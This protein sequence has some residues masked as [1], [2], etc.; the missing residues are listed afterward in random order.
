MANDISQDIADK[1]TRIA[2]LQRDASQR[3][4]RK[5]MEDIK[6][7]EDL[8][9]NVIKK[10]PGVDFATPFPVMSGILDTLLAKT[11][12]PPAIEYVQQEEADLKAAKKY[13]AAW[14]AESSSPR[15]HARWAQKD[16]F[17]KKLAG[18]SGRG[19]FQF[20]SESDPRYRS[21]LE[22]VDHYD[23][24]VEPGGGSYIQNH[25]YVQKDN[26]FRTKH[27]LKEGAK[28]RF[29]DQAQVMKLFSFNEGQT[30]RDLQNEYDDKLNRLRA[31]GIEA[32]SN[33]FTGEQLY[34]LTEAYTTYEGQRYQL[35]YDRQSGIW[36]RIAKLEEVF[37]HELWPFVSWATHEDPFLFWSKAPADDIRPVADTI[38]VL[39]NQELSNRERRNFNK[40]AFDEEMFEASDLDEWRR[41]KLVPANTSGGLKELSRGV[42][43]FETPEL[44]GTI[45]L[46]SFMDNF[47]GQKTGITPGAQGVSEDDKKVGV[48]FGELQQVSD[49]LGLINKSY[50]MGWE[51]LGYMYKHGLEE[52]LNYEM[53]ITLV[54]IEGVERTR[55]TRKDLRTKSDFDVS[56]VSSQ[57]RAQVQE[58]EQ[59]R[60]ERALDRIVKSGQ[61]VN[62]RWL[63]EEIL[64]AGGYEE[65]QIA[66]ALDLENETSEEL[67]SEAAAAIQDILR[68]RTPSINRKADT[69]FMQK[70]VDFAKDH[71]T[72]EIAKDGSQILKA[73]DISKEVFTKLVEYAMQH[74]MI[75]TENMQ[76]K[77]IAPTQE[78]Q[79]EGDVPQS[80]KPREPE[81]PSPGRVQEISARLSNEAVKAAQ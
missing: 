20:F 69:A 27:Q 56:V 41:D 1:V 28:S 36:V 61:P 23:L 78:S 45:N 22:V 59:V 24:H 6:K 67:M 60:K 75:A 55:I 77:L 65:S 49:R 19:T 9:F 50:R 13:T 17:T 14:Q 52:N 25:L 12:D 31:M 70:I 47:I 73:G 11:D 48:F 7:S 21:V 54:G 4:K 79:G 37:S 44:N 34:N 43:Q 64:R 68:G 42:Y 10:Q 29:Y 18:F 80:E 58:A 3:A 51:E 32:S 46:A 40:T 72:I 62:S 38:N 26:V 5:R 71:S 35:F 16:R 74:A 63:R 39:M 76:K 8:Y 15:P 81:A 30:E 53:A 2:M 57:D 33:N 66:L